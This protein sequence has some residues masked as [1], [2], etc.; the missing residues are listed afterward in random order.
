[1]VGDVPAGG[2]AVGVGS[3]SLRKGVWMS[4]AEGRSYFSSQLVALQHYWSPEGPIRLFI[5]LFPGVPLPL[6]H[7]HRPPRQAA[8]LTCM[9]LFVCVLAKCTLLFYVHVSFTDVN[10]RLQQNSF[11]GRLGGSVG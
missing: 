10:E 6:L 3:V 4:G 2:P 8:V 5:Y 7:S 11:C 1:M 9:L